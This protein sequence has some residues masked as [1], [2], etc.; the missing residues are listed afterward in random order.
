VPVVEILALP[1]SLVEAFGRADDPYQDWVRLLRC[2]IERQENGPT[3]LSC[4][5]ATS[6]G[7]S[8]ALTKLFPASVRMEKSS[9]TTI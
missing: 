5:G 3:R 2:A 9:P 6:A 4:R 1:P 8:A 7:Q